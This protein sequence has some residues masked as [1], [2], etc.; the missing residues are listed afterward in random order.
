MEIEK[1]I[2]Q[3]QNFL[4]IKNYSFVIQECKKLLIKYPNDSFLYNL[5]GLA[6]QGNGNIP[7]S[8]EY[9][10]KSIDLEPRNIAAKNNLANSYKSVGEIN[11]AE[12]L[13]NDVLKD[14]PNHIQA[15]NNYANLKETLG[16]NE[17]SI[18][19]YN[20]A[21]KINPAQTNILY[22]LATVY[23]NIGDFDKAQENF[24]KVIL[25]NPKHSLAHRQLSYMIKYSEDNKEHLKKMLY[26]L[27]DPNLD[28]FH[29]ANLS[30]AVGKAYDDLNNYDNSFKYFDKANKLLSELSSYDF[31]IDKNLFK[32]I[33][34][35]FE[36]ID[37]KKNNLKYDKR[38]IIFICGMPRS[39][40]TLIEQII[41]SHDQVTGFGEL[42]YLNRLIR[43]NY[44]LDNLLDY[45]K[46]EESITYNLNPLNKGY[47]NL[48][49]FHE[50]KTNYSTDKT[51]L[52]F[53]WIGIIK[54]FFPNCKIIHCKRD[55]KD[56]CLS[57]FKNSFA[58]N[59]M[60]WTN[61]ELNIVN[62]YKEYLKIMSFWN[63]KFGDFI[64]EVQY[65]EIVKNQKNEI[66]KI[67]NFCNLEWDEK[68]LKYYE[69][70]KTPIKTLSVNQARQKIY[71]TSMHSSQFYSKKLKTMF[72]ALEKN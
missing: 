40:T 56:T 70:N 22:S 11:L 3:L 46:I 17:M 1:K 47:F 8:I 10:K 58:A 31:Q 30:F 24:K 43:K 64:Y 27:N 2:Q 66:K 5:C 42:I 7:M 41:A 34:K 69:K 26:L 15:L 49:D 60:L 51:P 50:F 6:L 39:G 4:K 36:K 16:Y 33:K 52:N 19:F 54:L 35:I 57:I 28:N 12:K 29:K 37:F 55:P 45:K 62:Y 53:K 20:K 65:E 9:F 32:N 59:D 63:S 14:N 18:N 25:I 44:F 38:K 21:L 13:Y 71:D 67:I 23:Q 68:C 72:D 48:L 61:N